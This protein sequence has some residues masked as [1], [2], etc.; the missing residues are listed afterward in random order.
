MDTLQQKKHILQQ[1]YDILHTYT[2]LDQLWNDLFEHDNKRD[3]EGRALN[4]IDYITSTYSIDEISMMSINDIEHILLDD[5]IDEIKYAKS[6]YT[7]LFDNI[8]RLID[9]DNIQ[10]LIQTL[11]AELNPI[12]FD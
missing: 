3:S 5:F 4:I 2:E 11:R 9:E 1:K 6:H 8:Q 10:D 7:A 12:I